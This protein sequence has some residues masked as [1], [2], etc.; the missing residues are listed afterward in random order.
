MFNASETLIELSI[1]D[2][3]RKIKWYYCIPHYRDG[4]EIPCQKKRIFR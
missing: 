3:P 4:F 2:G 1:M